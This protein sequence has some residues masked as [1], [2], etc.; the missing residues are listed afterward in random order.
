MPESLGIRE[1]WAKGRSLIV[2]FFWLNFY[3]KS[4][5][6]RS[7]TIFGVDSLASLKNKKKEFYIDS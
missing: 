4:G 7:A 1:N 2:Y 5:K 6:N 3:L